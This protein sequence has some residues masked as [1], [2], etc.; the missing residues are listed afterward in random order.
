AAKEAGSQ[1][2]GYADK[3]REMA[4]P[5]GKKVQ[6]MLGGYADP[7]IY[8]ARFVGAVLKQVYIAESLA[9]PKSLNA[10]TSSYKTL[11]SRVIDANYFPSLIK[12]GEWKKVGVYA[13]EAYGIFTI[14]EMLGR[15]SLVG[16]KLEKHGNAHH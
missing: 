14:G 16:Y 9:P 8:N 7:L 13:V 2:S 15:R 11:Y 6:G 5:M 3:L 1:L 4:G 10:L 12:S